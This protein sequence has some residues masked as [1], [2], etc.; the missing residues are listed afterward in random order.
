M[1]LADEPHI[2][3]LMRAVV[4][5]SAGIGRGHR[6]YLEG[7]H[8][9]FDTLASGGSSRLAL[10]REFANPQGRIFWNLADGLYRRGSQGGAFGAL[11]NTLR[12]NRTATLSRTTAQ[13]ITGRLFETL[14][15]EYL[16]VDHPL[17]A[18]AAR[19]LGEGA[20]VCYAHGEIATP[21]EALVGDIDLI[22]TPTH[23]CAQ[24]FINAGSERRISTVTGHCVETS[25]ALQAEHAFRSRLDRFRTQER[26]RIAFFSSGAEPT[27][28]VSKIIQAIRSTLAEGYIVY[29]FSRQDGRLARA[30]RQAF[31]TETAGLNMRF[32]CDLAEEERAVAEVFVELDIFVA[33]AHERT[34]WAL[35]LGFPIFALA[36]HIGPFAPRNWLAIEHTGVGELLSQAQ[37]AR[38][39]GGRLARMRDA[40]ALTRMAER[41]FAAERLDGFRRGAEEILRRALRTVT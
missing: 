40:G 9:A 19:V 31:P 3:P 28:H 36:P 4:F 8:A 5:V 34:H 13:I 21:P 30:T 22:L 29:V 14:A 10:A 20:R 25:L 38:E 32:C 6:F 33:P 39:L 2:F 11:Y 35:A 26:L 7:L 27:P 18:T 16:V 23:E 12:K 37:D 1:T 15:S 41:G 24:A 17:I